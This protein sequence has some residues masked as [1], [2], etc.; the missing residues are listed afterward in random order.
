MLKDP[1]PLIFFGISKPNIYSYASIL[2]I[3]ELNI[4][5]LEKYEII[6]HRGSLYELKL[7]SLENKGLD[8]G[9]KLRER[10]FIILPFSLFTS[11]FSDFCDFIKKKIPILKKI[12]NNTLIIAGGWHTTGR[13]EQVLNVGAD[14]VVRGEAEIQFPELLRKIYDFYTDPTP[15]RIDTNFFNSSSLKLKSYN[16]PVLLDT[17]PPYSEKFRVY[18]PIEISRGCPFHCKFCQAGN[19]WNFMRHAE[20]KN[21]V[22]WIKRAV[23]VANYKRVWFNSPNSF[24]YGSKKGIGTNPKAV[25]NLL[26]QIHKIDGLDEIFFGTFPSEVRPDFVTSEMMDTVYPFINNEFF[27]VGAQTASD[28]LLKKIRRG[29]TFSDVLDAIDLIL[30][31]GYGVVLDFIFGLPG[32][33]NTDIEL[34]LDFFKEILLNPKKIRIHTHTF[35]PLPM[36]PF[37]N[38]P[39]GKIGPEIESMVGKLASKN[40]AFGQYRKQ[41][42]KY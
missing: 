6:T 28:M 32:E 4:D 40:K 25:K 18:A 34:T 31:F 29:H 23:K 16:T 12:N 2:S 30:D 11:Q 33:T 5:I 8:E 37:E 39:V 36:T 27:A 10:P 14:F 20:I 21:I 3:L 26:T 24:A 38:E 17:Y 1:K 15:Q 9:L 13:P 22:K 7:D 41:S 42:L 35:M 19:Y